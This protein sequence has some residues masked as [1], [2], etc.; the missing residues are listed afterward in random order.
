MMGVLWRRVPGQHHSC[1][2]REQSGGRGPKAAPVH[3]GP[4]WIREPGGLHQPFRTDVC[5]GSRRLTAVWSTARPGAKLRA[6]VAGM[7]APGAR[8]RS[9]RDGRRTR[10]V[11]VAAM[12]RPLCG[13]THAYRGGDHSSSA[14]QLR[15][16]SAFMSS[17]AVASSIAI[18]W[19]SVSDGGLASAARQRALSSGGMTA[20]PRS[21]QRGG[22]AW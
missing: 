19:S 18:D 20:R 4:P 7:P 1:G 21:G 13:D 6:P 22:T 2:K 14:S 8:P 15:I 5:H 12:R 16:S 3:A 9:R 10:C 17:S 11:R